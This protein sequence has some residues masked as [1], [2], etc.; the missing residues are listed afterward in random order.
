MLERVCPNCAELAV[1]PRYPGAA[2]ERRRGPCDGCPHRSAQVG[3]PGDQQSLAGL[4]GATFAFYQASYYPQAPFQPDWTFDA[5]FISFV[6][7]LGTRSGSLIG[8]VFY[9]LVR[10]QLTLTLGETQQTIFGLLF[11]VVVLALP[12]GL[13]NI[14]ARLVKLITA[15]RNRFEARSASP[16]QAERGVGAT[17]RGGP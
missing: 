17:N 8:V 5:L 2:R 3:R 13:V 12:G 10:Q 7:G 16:Q 15:R 4:A 11:T 9:I 14:W 6:G 1:Q